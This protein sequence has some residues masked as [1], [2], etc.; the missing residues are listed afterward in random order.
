MKLW[1]LSWR[2][3][4]RLSVQPCMHPQ[5]ILYSH[6]CIHCSCCTSLHA[7]TVFNCKT[8]PVVQTRRFYSGNLNSEM[9]GDSKDAVLH[10]GDVLC[11]TAMRACIAHSAKCTRSS[12]G[13]HILILRLCQLSGLIALVRNVQFIPA[14]FDHSR[15]SGVVQD[16]DA[17][18]WGGELFSC[19]F[20][21]VFSSTSSKS[22][23]SFTALQGL[24]QPPQAALQ[25]STGHCQLL[26][27][28]CCVP[29]CTILPA[30][31]TQKCGV[32]C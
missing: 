16:C 10:G 19:S 25:S 6:A 21:P 28:P 22:I 29:Y 26:C 18:F 12:L 9:P 4:G 17:S 30:A 13:T 20:P 32:Q 1:S 15:P 2:Q 27:L 8:F 11:C 3:V 24:C 5:L 23:G 31:D 7:S 14:H